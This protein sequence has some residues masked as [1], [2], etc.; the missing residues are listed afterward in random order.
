MFI[1]KIVNINN[2]L[3]KFCVNLLEKKN[4][5]KVFQYF[6]MYNSKISQCSLWQ[7]DYNYNKTSLYVHSILKNKY[8]IK[9][10]FK[11]TEHNSIWNIV[12]KYPNF[13]SFVSQSND[14]ASVVLLFYY[15]FLN[16]FAG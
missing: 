2:K 16:H 1:F 5:L 11:F 10:L 6:K 3:I 13:T 12:I 4:K 14:T 8:I 9:N 15:L 7:M